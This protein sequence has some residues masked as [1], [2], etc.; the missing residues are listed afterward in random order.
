MPQHALAAIANCSFKQVTHALKAWRPRWLKPNSD[1]NHNDSR[2]GG[3]IEG[4][5]E[6]GSD[7]GSEGGSEG[8]SEGDSEGE[9]DGDNDSRK[10]KIVDV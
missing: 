9:S 10:R 4:G 8:D 1:S 6:G 2:S 5:S 7:G 3:D